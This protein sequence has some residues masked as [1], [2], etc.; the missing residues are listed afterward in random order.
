M[1][2]LNETIDENALKHRKKAC[3]DIVYG[4]VRNSILQYYFYY[5]C[6]ILCP[7]MHC[8]ERDESNLII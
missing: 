6:G 2:L 1:G 4:Y 5:C 8:V 3:R 7:T